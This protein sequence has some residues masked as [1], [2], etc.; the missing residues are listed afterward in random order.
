MWS[1]SVVELQR[2]VSIGGSGGGQGFSFLDGGDGTDTGDG[3]GKEMGLMQ[4]KAR[5]A[6][7]VVLCVSFTGYPVN[8]IMLLV[9]VL[10]G[11]PREE[12]FYFYSAQQ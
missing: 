1:G 9:I 12:L 7:I 2:D 5:K 11:N 4:Q 6:T 10:L 3:G 8:V